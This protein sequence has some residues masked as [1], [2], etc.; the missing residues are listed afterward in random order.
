LDVRPD[1]A[2]DRADGPALTAADTADELLA[3]DSPTPRVELDEAAIDAP[4]PK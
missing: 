2:I 3:F 1:D 4:G